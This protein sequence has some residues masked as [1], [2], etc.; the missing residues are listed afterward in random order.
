MFN[1]L[2]SKPLSKT[3]RYKEFLKLRLLC[4]KYSFTKEQQQNN[5]TRNI[6]I[7]N[8]NTNESSKLSGYDRKLF[9]YYQSLNQKT[10][11]ILEVAKEKG[12]TGVF[13][14]LTNQSCFHPF[15]T[16]NDRFNILNKN[17]KFN[18]IDT[19]IKAGYKN[20]N[21]IFR[22]FYKR[23]KNISKDILYICCYEPHKSLIPHLHCLLF[24]KEEYILKVKK[25]F[26]KIIKEKNLQRIDFKILNNDKVRNHS[27]VVA[28]YIKK[29]MFKTIF[30]ENKEQ[31]KSYARFIDG[32]KKKYKIRQFKTSNL[33]LTMQ[34][35]KKLYHS[36]PRPYLVN[37]IKQLKEEK[38]SLFKYFMENVNITKRVKNL[39]F[40]SQILKENPLNEN[41]EKEF[42]V[43]INVLEKSIISPVNSVIKKI[44]RIETF[45]IYHNLID[46]TILG[47]L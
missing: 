44:S 11:A 3:S 30:S 45:V 47:N 43:I 35:Y 41:I 18:S 6:A 10:T 42:E 5:F 12:L 36:L 32:W 46:E 19:S 15:I 39:T 27:A 37:L 25:L 13:F 34:V 20:L 31:A 7:V 4:I 22:T 8:H 24:I 14:T 16:Y 23:V 21:E 1:T 29:Y 38:K 28:A 33:P 40:N 2:V 26:L 9:S 17:F